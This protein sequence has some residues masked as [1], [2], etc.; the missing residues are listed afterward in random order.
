MPGG[1]DVT[2]LE[3]LDGAHAHNRL[4][5]LAATEFTVKHYAG[6]VTYQVIGFVEKNGD[7]VLDDQRAA[8]LESSSSLVRSLFDD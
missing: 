6:L 7:R 4:L 3:K 5:S 8:L 1:S 2:F